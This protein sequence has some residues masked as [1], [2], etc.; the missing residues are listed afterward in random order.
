MLVQN[1][2]DD[3]HVGDHVDHTDQAR[4]FFDPQPKVVWALEVPEDEKG[5][6]N[7]VKSVAHKIDRGK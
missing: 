2:R 6:E 4:S 7:K 5:Q 3:E 1:Y